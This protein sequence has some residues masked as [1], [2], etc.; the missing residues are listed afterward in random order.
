MTTAPPPPRP[1]RHAVARWRRHRCAYMAR[2]AGVDLADVT[3]HGPDGI[4]TREDLAAHLAT[5]TG[6]RRAL[7]AA[8]RGT[9]VRGVQKHMAEAMVRSVADGAAGLRVPDGRRHADG[10]AGRSA[11]RANRHFEG[12]HVTPL[13]VVARAV[14]LA[15]RV[16]PTLEL[17]VGRAPPA[18]S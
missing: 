2:Q 12:L 7:P 14:V 10:G 8:R 11:P 15:L 13:A 3:G 6:G 18:R 17:V 16:H 1:E 5:G 9:P 4:I